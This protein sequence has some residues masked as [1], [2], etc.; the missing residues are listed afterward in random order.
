MTRKV[1]QFT[2]RDRVFPI[3]YKQDGTAKI[4]LNLYYN[5]PD[6]VKFLYSFAR[7]LIGINYIS[8]LIFSPIWV[9]WEIWQR[10][11]KKSAPSSPEED[12]AVDPRVAKLIRAVASVVGNGKVPEEV[13]IRSLA[14]NLALLRGMEDGVFREL[15]DKAPKVYAMADIYLKYLKGEIGDD[16]LVASLGSVQLSTEIRMPPPPISMETNKE[17][18][19]SDSGKREAKHPGEDGVFAR[20]FASLMFSTVMPKR[21]E[22]S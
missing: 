17:V 21:S 4:A 3:A 6:F 5:N 10:K 9:A 1:A 7:Y 16:E 19:D 15:G 13:A 22:D 18:G 14:L 8:R 2:S 12:L 20:L 11:T